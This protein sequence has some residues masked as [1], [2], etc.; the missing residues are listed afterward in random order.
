MKITAQS[1]V[2]TSS[3]KMICSEI[4]YKKI[5]RKEL[6]IKFAEELLKQTSLFSEI[7]V[8]TKSYPAIMFEMKAIVFDVNTASRIISILNTSNL[9]I[10]KIIELKQIFINEI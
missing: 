4:E 3:Y 2:D 1:T 7:D 10:E 6:S 9:P 8:S 5:I